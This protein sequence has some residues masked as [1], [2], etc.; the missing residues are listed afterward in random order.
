[1]GAAIEVRAFAITVGEWAE[2]GV[3]QQL[4]IFVAG[5]QC[6]E[7]QHGAACSSDVATGM[8]SA[9]RSSSAAPAASTQNKRLTL[10][11]A[12]I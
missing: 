10:I 5:E 6:V 3:L 4:S 2:S 7:A 11:L 8:Q 1:M 9:N 12:R